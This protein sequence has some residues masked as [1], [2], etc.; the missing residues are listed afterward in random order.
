MELNAEYFTIV[1]IGCAD[2][3]E[4]PDAEIRRTD[5]TAVVKCKISQE[6]WHLV[7]RGNTWIGDLNNCTIEITDSKYRI[8]KCIHEIL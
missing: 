5:S 1:A 2:L 6:T 8:N 4:L 7:C 3:E